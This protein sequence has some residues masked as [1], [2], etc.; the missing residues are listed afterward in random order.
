MCNVNDLRRESHFFFKK[1]L[2]ITLSI[3]VKLKMGIP[4]KVIGV[5]G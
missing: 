4:M 2:D 3:K 5:P 1:S